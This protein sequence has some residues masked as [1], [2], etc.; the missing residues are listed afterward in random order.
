M[1]EIIRSRAYFRSL[2]RLSRSGRFDI[3]KLENVIIKIKN[4][5]KLD[6]K[7]ADHEL[8]GRFMVVRECHVEPDLLLMYKIEKEILLLTLLN[9]GSHSYLFG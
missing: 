8:K 9:L 4:G 6:Q 7:H 3:S 2:K 1:Y 5:Q